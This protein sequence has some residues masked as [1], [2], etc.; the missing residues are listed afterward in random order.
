M[1]ELLKS[2]GF[3]W[4]VTVGASIFLAVNVYAKLLEVQYYRKELGK[5]DKEI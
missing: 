2:K 5:T 4:T 3:G 1:I